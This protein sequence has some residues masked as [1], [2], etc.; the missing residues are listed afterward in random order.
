M[1]LHPSE[2][3]FL[4][5]L[6]G[7]WFFLPPRSDRV[8]SK[9]D[10]KGEKTAV[11]EPATMR[12]LVILAGGG[13]AVSVANVALS[14][15]FSVRGFVDP[16]RKG[17]TVLEVPVVAEVEELGDPAGMA[18][19][20]A[21][22]DNAVRQRIHD[23]MR[24]RYGTLEYPP[25]V[26]HSAVLSVNARLGEGCVVMPGAIIGPNSTLGRFCI[27]NTRAAIDHD[28]IMADFASLAPGAITGGEVRIGLRTAIGIGAVIK[29][30]LSIGEDAV[31]GA[32]SYLHRDL[33]AN[34]LAH[35]SP[36]RVVRARKLGEPYL[37]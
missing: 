3:D 6:Y 22:G 16:N 8:E 37:S 23:D 9:T 30:G 27:L 31:L 2:C 36:A 12:D 32:N 1:R 10:P 26:H 11:P 21:A 29:H 17:T 5:L 18:L 33:P 14:A 7:T 20:I 15:G 25:L 4:R 24:A 34:T 19:A 35:G 13:H 28:C